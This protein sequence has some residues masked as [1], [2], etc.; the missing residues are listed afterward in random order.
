MPYKPPQLNGQ[1]DSD[2][3]ESW[4]YRRINDRPEQYSIYQS[5]TSNLAAL[6]AAI[7]ITT[8]RRDESAQH[9]FGIENGWKYLVN[10]LNAPADPIYLHIIDKCLEISGSTLH[11]TY[12]KQFVKLML[13]LRDLY[14]PNMREV[15]EGMKAAY[16]RLRQITIAKFFQENRFSQPKGKLTARYW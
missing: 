9:P 12:G 2:F 8:S 13:A 7:W 5:R 10:I 14:L 16:D 15:D 11:L 4:G 6:M 3:L 1:S